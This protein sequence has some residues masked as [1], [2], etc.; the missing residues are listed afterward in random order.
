MSL[1]LTVIGATGSV[2][3]H[4]VQQALAEGHRVTALTR[5]PEQVE[6]REGLEVIGGDVLDPVAVRS[7]VEGRDAVVVALGDGRRGTVREA[8]TRAVVEAM[9]AG[10]VRRLVVQSTLG[11]GDSRANLDLVWK[12]LM[13]GLLLRKAYADHQRQE[14]V[15]R[16]SGLDWTIVRP[17]AFTDGPRTGSYQRGFGP[18]AASTLKIS[19]ADVA[20]ALLREL[21]E[22]A[23]VGR[24]VA[25][26]Y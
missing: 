6:P 17:A 26:A 23:E 14:E 20:H 11:A 3:R 9:Q 12:H 25:V 18:E 13:F 19:R 5:R 10:G 15:V 7:A 8:G 22:E 24:A 16:A 1:H 21:G 4:V 2:G